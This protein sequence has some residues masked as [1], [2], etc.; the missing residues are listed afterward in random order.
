MNIPSQPG[1]NESMNINPDV[2][3]RELSARHDFQIS[4]NLALAQALFEV[5]EE[6]NQLR[7]ELDAL[8]KPKEAD[9]GAAE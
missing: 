3:Y 4:R 8:T 1:K 9:N 7:A 5:T 2:A 6:R